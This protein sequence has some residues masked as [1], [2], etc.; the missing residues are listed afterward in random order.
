M[1]PT[2]LYT[3]CFT[4]TSHHA[5]HNAYQ[6]AFHYHQCNPTDWVGFVEKRLIQ[7]HGTEGLRL[8]EARV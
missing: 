4:R 1:G 3:H 7:V 5:Y 8:M 2:D 6:S